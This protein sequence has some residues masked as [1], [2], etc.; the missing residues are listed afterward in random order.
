MERSPVI[1]K[2]CGRHRGQ[3]IVK[4]L[5]SSRRIYFWSVVKSLPSASFL[6]SPSQLF[7]LSA[8]IQDQLFT[9]S[10]YVQAPKRKL[11]SF[12]APATST[13]HKHIKLSAPQPKPSVWGRNGSASAALFNT[14]SQRPANPLVATAAQPKPAKSLVA[15]AALPKQS[16]WGKQ[17]A[18][19]L[20]EAA[21]TKPAP[22]V[23]APVVKPATAPAKVESVKLPTKTLNP[24]Y[25]EF[26]SSPRKALNPVCQVFEPHRSISPAGSDTSVGSNSTT[27]SSLS[28]RS[29]SSASSASSFA[30]QTSW[31]SGAPSARRASVSSR[32]T[33]VVGQICW[34]PTQAQIPAGEPIHQHPDFINS[35]AFIHPCVVV[36]GA[37]A[38]GY[39]TCLQLT[40]FHVSNGL[41]N[42]YADKIGANRRTRSMASQRKRW[43]LFEC[44][45]RMP[46]HD[47]L[48]TMR[49]E[50]TSSGRMEKATYIN[51][52]KW[53]KIRPSDLVV[54]GPVM[55]LSMCSVE[56]AWQHHKF[57]ERRHR[58]MSVT[59]RDYPG[60][61]P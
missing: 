51:C 26:K 24:S 13:S 53:F 47:D 58:V 22:Q 41:L 5:Q 61:M 45:N 46:N 44:N 49:Y 23:V 21:S 1:N 52:E 29:H 55:K 42:K 36:E 37:D 12:D 19:V 38:K 3:E 31:R 8:Y 32:L 40:S 28:W 35:K 16:V 17:S 34:L 20:L 2:D 11:D 56:I 43:L 48:P 57:L 6:F 39:L 60:L 10:A 59:R 25:Q 30:S 27:A 18:A 7:S 9:M 14:A 50:S 4:D 15:A 54:K 33:P